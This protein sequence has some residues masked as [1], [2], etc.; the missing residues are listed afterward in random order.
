MLI[1]LSAASFDLDGA[2]ELDVTPDLG[3]QRR[4]VNRIATLD[5]GVVFNDFG[6]TDGDRTI[7]LAWDFVSAAQ[8]ALVARLVRLYQR[9]TLSCADGVFS[10]APESYKASMSG[11]TLSLLVIEKLTT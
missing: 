8:E 4:R 6:Y 9:L 11:S 1:T 10:V 7:N 2:V 3:A 5:G